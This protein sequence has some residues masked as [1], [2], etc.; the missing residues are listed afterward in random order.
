[1]KTVSQN[2]FWFVPGLTMAALAFASPAYS[3]EGTEIEI[4]V[5]DGNVLELHGPAILH[6]HEHFGFIN[7][8][9]SWETNHDGNTW[10]GFDAHL[11]SAHA[12][13]NFDLI[14]ETPLYYWDGASSGFTPMTGDTAIRLSHG[15]NN[16]DITGQSGSQTFSNLVSTDSNGNIHSHRL[17]QLIGDDGEP[18]DGAYLIGIR[19]DADGYEASNLQGILFHKGLDHEQYE[20]AENLALAVIPEPASLALVGLGGAAMLLRRRRASV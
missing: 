10:P 8:G 6:D 13:V 16:L 3:H 15:G 14:A 7:A 12:N 9:G 5:E 17:W 2:K 4:E 19:M 20:L 1:M 18:A 11:G